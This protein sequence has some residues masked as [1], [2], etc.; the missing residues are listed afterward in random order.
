MT[1]TACSIYC[2]DDFSV[3]LYLPEDFLFF[4]IEYAEFSFEISEGEAGMG[5]GTGCEGA[6]F[7]SSCIL[8]SGDDFELSFGELSYLD[9]TC[10]TRTLAT[11]HE[12]TTVRYPFDVIG[13]EVDTA[14][15]VFD[16]L[17]SVGGFHTRNDYK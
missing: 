16:D 10:G 6:A 5:G 4:E 7:D 12:F 1:V 15:E 2:V 11:D 14:G 9:Q 3:S 13:G 8:D 17:G